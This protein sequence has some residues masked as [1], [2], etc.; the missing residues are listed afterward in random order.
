MQC[1]AWYA[2]CLLT[3]P[4]CWLRGLALAKTAGFPPGALPVL[5][6]WL[7]LVLV[8]GLVLVL[9]LVLGC[10]LLLQWLPVLRLV[11]RLDNDDLGRLLGR[12]GLVYR[13]RLN[14]HRLLHGHHRNLRTGWFG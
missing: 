7:V 1:P 6:L 14:S 12:R 5:H 2:E 13:S 3:P 4:T 11:G 10:I 8:L 9:L